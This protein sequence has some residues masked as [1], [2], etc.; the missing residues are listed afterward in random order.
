MNKVNCLIIDDDAD[1]RDIFEI[2]LGESDSQFSL[3]ALDSGQKA[4]EML[5]TGNNVPDYIFLDLNM[6][7]LS[8]KECLSEI[9]NINGLD[10]VPVVIYSTSSYSKDIEDTKMLGANH[11]L[12]KTPDIRRLSEILKEIFSGRELPYELT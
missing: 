6:P 7:L 11:F 10:K 8:G 12:T 1:D 5:S 9:R 2:A 4:L 3:T